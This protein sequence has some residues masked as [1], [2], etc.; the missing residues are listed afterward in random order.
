VMWTGQPPIMKRMGFMPSCVADSP[1][2]A[3]EERTF[4]VN[5]GL[6]LMVNAALIFMVSGRLMRW[7]FD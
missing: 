7:R 2:N 6:I 5:R 4:M 3:N 1:A